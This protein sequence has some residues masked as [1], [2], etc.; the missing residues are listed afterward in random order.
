MVQQV[1]INLCE[2]L[3]DPRVELDLCELRFNVSLLDLTRNDL[4]WVEVLVYLDLDGWI[5]SWLDFG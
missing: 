5:F 4:A 1:S 3:L 2:K